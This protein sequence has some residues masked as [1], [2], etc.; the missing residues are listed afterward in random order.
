MWHD[1]ASLLP[2]EPLSIEFAQTVLSGV[3]DASP[4]ERSY[5]QQSL[6]LSFLSRC[7]NIYSEHHLQD[8]FREGVLPDSQME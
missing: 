7:L 6:H 8:E 1:D 3:S 2:L 4:A 5:P